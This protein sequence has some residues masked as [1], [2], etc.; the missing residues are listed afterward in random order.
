MRF[1]A[2]W[3]WLESRLLTFVLVWQIL[4]L[5]SWVFLNGLIAYPLIG[6]WRRWADDNIVTSKPAFVAY[7]LVAKLF[8]AETV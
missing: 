3:T 2:K 5:V 4:A 8:G 6:G 1:E 7:K